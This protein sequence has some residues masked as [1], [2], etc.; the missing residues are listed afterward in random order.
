MHHESLLNSDKGNQFPQVSRT[1]VPGPE[2]WRHRS[3]AEISF[4]D[5]LVSFLHQPPGSNLQSRT[6]N[7]QTYN[8]RPP[9]NPREPS[10]SVAVDHGTRGLLF[11]RLQHHASNPSSATGRRHTPHPPHPP[12][13]DRIV[14]HDS[15][16]IPDG[17]QVHQPNIGGMQVEEGQEQNQ[18]GRV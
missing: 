2:R 4:V 7:T 1:E 15:T 13:Q 6:L 11:N 18:V 17:L 9:H 3:L 10:N 12:H 5:G 8:A 14:Q 16:N